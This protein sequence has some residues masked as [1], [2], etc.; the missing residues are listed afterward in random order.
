MNKPGLLLLVALTACGGS[1]GSPADAGP[2]DAWTPDPI[3]RQTPLEPSFTAVTDDWVGG[4]DLTGNRLTLADLDGD[5]YPDLIVH[6]VPFARPDLDASPP[7]MTWRVLMNRPSAAG[8]TFED[9][10][11]TSG[12]GS[13]RDG[14]GNRAATFAVAGDYDNDGDLD[15]FSG[16][17]ADLDAL[18]MDS[19]DRNDL[20]LND[21]TGHFTRIGGGAVDQSGLP[22]H[23]TA[24]A[25]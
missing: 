22:W 3:C 18:G 24:A 8:R 17:Y 6:P 19:G 16:H 15:L 2:P 25:P 10:T 20:F 12:Y 14:S 13:A 1:S 21:G 9:A 7:V 11:L 5:R 23:T 4:L